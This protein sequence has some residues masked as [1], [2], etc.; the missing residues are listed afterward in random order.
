MT[1]EPPVTPRPRDPRLRRAVAVAAS[2]ALVPVLFAVADA[3]TGAGSI[4]D[5]G[6]AAVTAHATGTPDD[7]TETEHGVEVETPDSEAATPSGSEVTKPPT[8]EVEHGT[9]S[10][11]ESEHATES[12]P[13]HAT[14]SEPAVGG[15]LDGGAGT[16]PAPP[17]TQT[18]SSVGG[19]IDV[20]LADGAISLASSTSADG[21][22]Q[23]VHDNGPTRVEVR[24]SSNGVEWRI[25]IEL[26]NGILTSE[27]TEHG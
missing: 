12:E 11:P 21:F 19:S 7:T 16:T 9:E 23:E 5:G 24:F 6:P 26:V 2:V 22:T 17:V 14:E 13:E 18:F 4:L 20:T 15:G 8:P 25:R 10:E 3:A 27:I 1:T